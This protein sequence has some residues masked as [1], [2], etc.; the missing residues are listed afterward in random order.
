MH[1]GTSS[2]LLTCCCHLGHKW[3]RVLGIKLC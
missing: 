1:V 3:D 2:E